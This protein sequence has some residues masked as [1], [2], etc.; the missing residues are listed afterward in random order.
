[1]L[2]RLWETRISCSEIKVLS[3]QISTLDTWRE[4]IVLA[5][6]AKSVRKFGTGLSGQA[7]ASIKIHETAR[8]VERRALFTLS[9]KIL[10]IFCLHLYVIVPDHFVPGAVL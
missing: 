6:A 9:I 4:I 8:R 3:W 5:L 7:S 10:D 2:A 1:M